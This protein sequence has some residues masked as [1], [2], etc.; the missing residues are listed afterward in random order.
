[1]YKV[2]LLIWLISF[3]QNC[4][5]GIKYLLYEGIEPSE[6][7][8]H[9]C[10]EVGRENAQGRVVVKGGGFVCNCGKCL[11]IVLSNTFLALFRV[12]MV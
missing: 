4:R 11:F 5:P 3:A 12:M 6:N 1:M 2:I 9:Y 10:E 7:G 8:S